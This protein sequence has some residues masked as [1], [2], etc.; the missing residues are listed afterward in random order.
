MGATAA[1]ATTP[2][3]LAERL[4]EVGEAGMHA[5]PRG[6]GTKLAWGGIGAAGGVELDTRGLD[7]VLEH[8]EGDLTAIVAAGTPLAAAQ[9]RF[10][11]AGQMLALDPPLGAGDA[12]TVGGVLATADAGPLR[13]RYGTARD[14]VVGITVALSDGTVAKAGG[15][16]IKNVAG[17]DLAKLFIGSYGT[18]GVIL[19][20]NVRLH[21]RPTVTATVVAASSDADRLALAVAA[22]SRQPLEAACLDVAW[23]GDA[24]RVLV[25]FGGMTAEHQA[26]AVGDRLRSAGLEAVEA[27]TDDDPLWAAQRAGQRSASGVVVKVSA[28]PKDLAH[29][30]RAAKD[31]RGA[32][33]GRAA[34]GVSFVRL[35]GAD[36]AAR[37][38]ALRA[39]LAPRACTLLDG[40]EAVRAEVG[41]WPALGAGVQVLTERVKERFDPGRVLR[42]GVFVGGI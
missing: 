30:L 37:A 24:G 31:V 18:L 35:E 26:Q 14:L 38:T 15:N 6:A 1:R 4:R 19:A 21:P 9:E 32:V 29:V 28:R 11:A 39:A 16:V 2:Q 27:V 5:C 23:E 8:N 41:A 7:G 33:V 12:A 20:A 42:P 3:E 10:A 22:I 34:L 13:H 25:R 17:Y 36:L 40:P